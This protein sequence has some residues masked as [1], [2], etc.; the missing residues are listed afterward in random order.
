MKP[1]TLLLSVILIVAV[2]CS[3]QAETTVDD[4]SDNVEVIDTTDNEAQSVDESTDDTEMSDETE[5]EDSDMSDE[6][7]DSAMSDDS[8][9]DESDTDDTEASDD[10]M[11][12]PEA[13]VEDT[14]SSTVAYNGPDWTNIELVNAATNET[15]TLADFAG[16]TVFIE[17]MAVWCTNCR[18]Q[19]RTINTVIDQLDPNEFVML[20]LSIETFVTPEELATYAVNNEFGWTFAVATDDLVTALVN[21]FGRSVTSPPSVPHFTIAPDGTAGNFATGGESAE[22]FLS[23]VRSVA[24]GS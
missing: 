11:D 19:Q 16:K 7:D 3:P 20:S 17:P 1:I 21:E 8:M 23:L 12:E 22:E 9:E 10:A 4:T 13:V 24:A 18:S 15:F 5:M 14:T 6:M 2:A